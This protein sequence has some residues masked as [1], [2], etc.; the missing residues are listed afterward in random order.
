MSPLYHDSIRFWHLIV[1]YC[2]SCNLLRNRPTLSL[3][4]LQ[5]VYLLKR[6]LDR[7]TARL[8]LPLSKILKAKL[9]FNSLLDFPIVRATLNQA[10]AL[11]YIC[12]QSYTHIF[13]QFFYPHNLFLIFFAWIPHGQL[14]DT[15]EGPASLTLC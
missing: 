7:T 9:F 6:T 5:K 12:Q 10:I 2:I 15:A 1:S 13:S 3:S 8:M 4:T 14:W 11:L